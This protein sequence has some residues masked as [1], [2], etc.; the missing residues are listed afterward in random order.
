[1]V[2][3]Y[4]EAS[5]VAGLMFT[6]Y[7]LLALVGAALS[8]SYLEVDQN[9]L[10]AFRAPFWKFAIGWDEVRRVETGGNGIAFCGDNKIFV[11]NLTMGDRSTRNFVQYCNEQIAARGIQLEAVRM[12]PWTQK[13][14]RIN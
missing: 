9:R 12:I 6:I 4:V 8:W 13:N 14:T 1:M 7:T 5:W 3:A 2:M 10:F 11:M